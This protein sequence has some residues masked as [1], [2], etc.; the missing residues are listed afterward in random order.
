MRMENTINFYR[1]VGI[2]GCFS[3]FYPATF[4]DDNGNKYYNSEQ[5]FMK[6]KQEKF[7]PNN[8]NLANKILSSRLLLLTKNL[9]K[10]YNI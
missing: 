4:K 5:Y 3:N 7:D 9:S 10:H 6:K 2:Y 1:Q 8:I